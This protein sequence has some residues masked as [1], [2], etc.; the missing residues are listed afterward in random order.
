VPAPASI[1][2]AHPVSTEVNSVRNKGP[3]LIVE[4]TP[5]ELVDA[6]TEA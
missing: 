1:V 4:A 2:T 5:E 3:E 6:D